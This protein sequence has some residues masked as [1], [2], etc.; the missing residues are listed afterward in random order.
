MGV[1]I[2]CLFCHI[3]YLIEKLQENKYAYLYRCSSFKMFSIELMRTKD[4][5]KAMLFKLPRSV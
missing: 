5:I 1:Q 4:F 2:N 3:Q